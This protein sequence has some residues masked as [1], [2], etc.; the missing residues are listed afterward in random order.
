[1]TPLDRKTDTD[2]QSCWHSAVPHDISS[3]DHREEHQN[4]EDF[5]RYIS[6]KLSNAIS[7]LEDLRVLCDKRAKSLGLDRKTRRGVYRG[8]PLFGINDSRD[9][10]DEIVILVSYTVFEDLGG[11]VPRRVRIK[12]SNMARGIPTNRRGHG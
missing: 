8:E 11:K 10:G 12:T 5:C 6:W 3:R 7:K 4:A 9:V 2:G 1:M